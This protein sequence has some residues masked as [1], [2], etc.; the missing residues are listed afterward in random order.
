[1]LQL[2]PENTLMSIEKAVDAGSEGLVTDVT[3]R[4]VGVKSIFTNFTVMIAV[5]WSWLQL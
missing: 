4:S 2:A 3:I 1:M 5:V